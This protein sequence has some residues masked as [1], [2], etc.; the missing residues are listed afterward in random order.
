MATGENQLSKVTKAASIYVLVC[1]RQLTVRYIGKTTNPSQRLSTH[2]SASRNHRFN[3][4]AARWIRSLLA[5][6]IAPTFS[7]LFRVPTDM[8]WQ[9]A[10]RFFIASGT[11]FGF[12]LTNGTLGGEGVD[13]PP[14]EMARVQQ[15]RNS[16]YTDSVKERM[17]ANIRKAWSDPATRASTIEKMI[18]AANKPG[19]KAQLALIAKLPR[20]AEARAKQAMAIKASWQDP[21]K[22]AKRIALMKERWS[23]P[24]RR[25]KQS[26]AMKKAAVWKQRCRA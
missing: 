19:R 17:S 15:L 6:S 10:E 23:D 26:E 2:V 24:E 16:G 3:H 12:P 5:A 8:P 21:E 25:R 14:E 22:R 1:P 13:I 7:V 9:V 18:E 20:S 11:H 4:H